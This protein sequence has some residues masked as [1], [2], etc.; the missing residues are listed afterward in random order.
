MSCSFTLSPWWIKVDDGDLKMVYSRLHRRFTRTQE[1]THHIIHE[2]LMGF[3]RWFVW[4]MTL[5]TLCRKSNEKWVKKKSL[6]HRRIQIN[7]FRHW[8][9]CECVRACMRMRMLMNLCAVLP[10]RWFLFCLA[11]FLPWDNTSSVKS[12]VAVCKFFLE[13]YPND[14]TRNGCSQSS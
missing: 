1:H 12:I 7:R 8:G 9:V 6:K 2:F 3:Y 5:N 10:L 11:P 14:N 4:L 13:F